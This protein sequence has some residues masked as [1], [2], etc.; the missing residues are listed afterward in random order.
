M[1]LPRARSSAS[2]LNISFNFASM[3]S[4]CVSHSSPVF[5]QR[6]C[7]KVTDT[8]SESSSH[9]K[10]Q[11]RLF[12]LIFL[13]P[14]FFGSTLIF[15]KNS[16]ALSNSWLARPVRFFTAA[17]A[18]KHRHTWFTFLTVSSLP[19]PPADFRENSDD[20]THYH[21]LLPLLLL[22]LESQGPRR[23]RARVP[24]SRR[25]GDESSR[26]RLRRPIPSSRNFWVARVSLSR[27][28][29]KISAA[30]GTECSRNRSP[31]T[32]VRS[33][34]SCA[35]LISP[36]K[37]ELQTFAAINSAKVR[38]SGSFGSGSAS[39]FRYASPRVWLLGRPFG[40]PLTPLGQGFRLRS[41][42]RILS[43]EISMQL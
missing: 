22:C 15:P 26:M 7:E 38:P 13:S 3:I 24:L 37:A 17:Y 12:A 28:S 1:K 21:R 42:R 18:S 16:P 43:E 32:S 9:A 5:E 34:I 41:R 4:L 6:P 19:E 35:A 8:N 40:F 29:S 30:V 39:T 25:G 23:E 11:S 31:F 2:G 36:D 10:D 33:A 20:K 27:F 14:F